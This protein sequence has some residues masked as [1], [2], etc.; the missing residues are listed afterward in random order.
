MFR[1]F[2]YFLRFIVGFFSCWYIMPEKEKTI[3]VG[4]NSSMR[5]FYGKIHY[6]DVLN[7][8]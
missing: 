8:L 6:W 3:T 1:K 2:S 7:Y 5:E 4:E